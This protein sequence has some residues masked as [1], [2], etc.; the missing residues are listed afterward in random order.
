MATGRQ[1]T[2]RAFL[3][4]AA[5]AAGAAAL[6]IAPAFSGLFRT[7]GLSSPLGSSGTPANTLGGP[8]FLTTSEYGTA[9]A[10]CACILPTGTDPVTGAVTSPGAT[11]ANAVQF[12]DMFMAA[13][14]LPSALADN[15]AIYLQG[16]FSGRQPFPPAD[17]D[18]PGAFNFSPSQYP[19][20]QLELTGGQRQF[21][22]LSAQQLVSWYLQLYGTTAGLASTPWGTANQWVTSS[23]WSGAWLSQVTGSSPTIPGVAAG[24]LRGLYQAGLPAF[25]AWAEQNFG[26]PFAQCNPVE[27]D[28]LVVLASDPLVNALGS[29]GA[30]LPSPLPSPTPPPAAAALMGVLALHTIQGTYCLPEYGGNG[31]TRS[32]SAAPV[33]W[34]AIGWDGDT[35]PL[36]N[37]VYDDSAYGPGAGPNAGYGQ[38]GVYQPRGTMVEYRPTS[39]PDN[40][41]SLCT[42]ADLSALLTELAKVGTVTIPPGSVLP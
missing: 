39:Y 21:L 5:A 26:S 6:P 17:P 4:A 9:A 37:T 25:D 18:A 40:D 3:Q 20:D 38:A 7:A 2:R 35:E 13:F 1:I 14:E 30:S 22:G 28:A 41:Q 27:Q 29:N 15:P 16:R 32:P 31:G 12:I 42:L 24:G 33:T 19:A 8:F 10:I 36:G 23:S 11:E 34:A